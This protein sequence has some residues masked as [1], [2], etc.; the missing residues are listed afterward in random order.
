M[1][2]NNH[3][4]YDYLEL[5]YN[6]KFVDN[7]GHLII[8]AP[9][10]RYG[11]VDYFKSSGY[12]LI[13]T[14]V[15]KSGEYFSI[16]NDGALHK[17]GNVSDLIGT[18]PGLV[19]PTDYTTISRYIA[20]TDAYTT[21]RTTIQ[22]Y[23]YRVGVVDDKLA[24]HVDCYVSNDDGHMVYGKNI[25]SRNLLNDIFCQGKYILGENIP[26]IM[27]VMY[28][29]TFILG[30]VQLNKTKITVN[31]IK[32]VYNNAKYL[33]AT[34]KDVNGNVLKNA[35][36]SISLN[37]KVYSKVTDSKGQVKLYVNLPPKTYTAKITFYGD[38]KYIK[39]TAN[40]K[41]AVKKAKVKLAAK[42]I[43]FKKSKKIKKY[44]VTLKNNR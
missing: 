25:S 43:M 41:I 17:K 27:N 5:I 26:I 44:T 7:F 1:I 31:N 2:G 6:L 29:N 16:P 38:N 15:L 21:L 30:S 13:E 20:A 34:L 35:K 40:G 23:E 33:V 14:G 39:S 4:S 11:A 10:G 36:V 28:V 37:G 32:T 18:V 42:N 8:K 19:D 24:T 9:D 3:I 12:K 22:T